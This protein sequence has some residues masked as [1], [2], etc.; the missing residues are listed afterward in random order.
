MPVKEVKIKRYS[1]FK[2]F[3]ITHLQKLNFWCFDTRWFLLTAVSHV[4]HAACYDVCCLSTA[5]QDYFHSNWLKVKFSAQ[6]AKRKQLREKKKSEFEFL[7]Y[8][9][10]LKSNTS[11]A[12]WASPDS[13][14]ANSEFIRNEFSRSLKLMVRSRVNDFN[15]AEG[16][17]PTWHFAL[18]WKV[19][20]WVL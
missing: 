18:R 13:Y 11:Q 12:E 14:I 6:F 2:Y 15:S 1:N 4:D 8:V 19:D 9:A 10:R 16:H 3:S 7:K 5:I 20:L 17:M